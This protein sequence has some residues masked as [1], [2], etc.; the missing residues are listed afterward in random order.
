VA[1]EFSAGVQAGCA[2]LRA[3]HAA[4]SLEGTICA[5]FFWNGLQIGL[6]HNATPELHKQ[7]TNAS[8]VIFPI[9]AV[10]L[11]VVGGRDT[12]KRSA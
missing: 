12:A 3:V 1:Y 6:Y 5:F 11:Y 8:L 7:V 10:I 4:H 2:A 9:L